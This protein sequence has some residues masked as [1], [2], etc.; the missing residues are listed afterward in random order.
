MFWGF[1]DLEQSSRHHYQ[2]NGQITYHTVPVQ[3]SH[4]LTDNCLWAES[5]STPAYDWTGDPTHGPHTINIFNRLYANLNMFNAK[6]TLYSIIT[7]FDALEIS[8]I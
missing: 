3:A 5:I 7:P 6:L 8:C 4:K 1:T 2:Y